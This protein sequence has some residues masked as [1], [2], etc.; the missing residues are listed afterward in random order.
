MK[1]LINF[2]NMLIQFVVGIVTTLVG[3]FERIAPK[4]IVV[5]H[6]LTW[7][8][9]SMVEIHVISMDDNINKRGTQKTPFVGWTIAR[10][11]PKWL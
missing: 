9:Y 2:I 8:N 1:H 5:T 11:S 6:P 7:A 3:G 10:G 4:H